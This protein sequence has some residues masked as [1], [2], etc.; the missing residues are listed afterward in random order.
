MS[1]VLKQSE[2]Y[3][4][5][6][7]IVLPGEDGRKI[8]QSFDAKFKRVETSRLEEI[9]ENAKALGDGLITKE[10][11]DIVDVLKEIMVDWDGVEETPG[12]PLPFSEKALEAVVQL[13]S[14]AAQI[15]ETWFNS[16]NHSKTKNS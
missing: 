15:L 3:R 9:I 4:W 16:I 12:K 6:V 2:F 5:P 7:K 8:T 11:F 10:Q 14:V 13:P 1:F